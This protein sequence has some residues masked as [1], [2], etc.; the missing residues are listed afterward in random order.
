MSQ[1]SCRRSPLCVLFPR[2]AITD[3][4]RNATTEKTR[5]QELF[6]T[7]RLSIIRFS[8]RL[9]HSNPREGDKSPYSVQQF[10]HD[11]RFIASGDH[12]VRLSGGE[13]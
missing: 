12:S 10:F 9:A 2:K 8:A 13:G 4:L 7:L 5:V 6:Q 3:F 1:L 11:Q